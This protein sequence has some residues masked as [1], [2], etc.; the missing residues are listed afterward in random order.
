MLTDRRRTEILLFPVW[1]LNVVEC[2]VSP[3]KRDDDF[4]RCKRILAEA[5][6]EALRGCCD[7]KANS[8]L[9]R[10]YR[11]HNALTEDYRRN[12]AHV[13]KIGL[14]ALYTLQAVLEDGYLEL[15]EGTPLSAAIHAI[16]EAL[17]DAFAEAR[18][19][20]SAKKHAAKVIAHLQRDGYFSGVHIQ[21]EAA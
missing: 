9:R 14:I 18:L 3:D 12:G 2:G 19:D 7:T 4:Y 17:S 16:I 13:D 8:L 11:L 1:L 5:V 15:V 20:A 10:V 21:R 6:A